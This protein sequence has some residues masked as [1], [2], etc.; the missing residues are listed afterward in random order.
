MTTTRTLETPEAELKSSTLK[1]TSNLEDLK[2]CTFFVV[3]VPTPV[4]PEYVTLR[5]AEYATSS[6]TDF[7]GR[8]G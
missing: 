3:A 1:F 5:V 2:G 4:D 6:F 7:A 8:L